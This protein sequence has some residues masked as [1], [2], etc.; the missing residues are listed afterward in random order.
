MRRGI[1]R[2]ALWTYQDVGCGCAAPSACWETPRAPHEQVVEPGPF[3]FEVTAAEVH[4]VPGE[5]G[6]DDLRALAQPLVAYPRC[7]PAAADHVPVQ[8]RARTQAEVEPAIADHPD[9]DT[10][11]R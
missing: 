6:A 7:R 1:G 8:V 10:L 3:H 9:A 4:V 2:R 5:Q 11:P